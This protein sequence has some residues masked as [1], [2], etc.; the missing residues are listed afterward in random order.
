LISTLRRATAGS[1]AGCV[2]LGATIILYAVTAAPGLPLH[3]YVSEAGVPTYPHAGAFR[4]GIFLLAAGL[5]LLGGA[6]TP[7]APVAGA[8]LLLAGAA[9]V[10]S[11]TVSCSDG[12]PL[13]PYEITTAPDVIHAA[14]SVLAVGATVLGMAALARPGPDRVLRACALGALALA[15]PL[16]AGVGLA[17]L[18]AGRGTAIG[19]LERALLTVT[20]TWLVLTAARVAVP[21]PDARSRST[22]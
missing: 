22:A 11:G 21:A 12:C 18:L 7:A 19:V 13:P 2:A 9:T 17:M 15:G 14:A 6:L 5:A 3:T 10:G 4:L 20:A 8:L 16:S 1:A